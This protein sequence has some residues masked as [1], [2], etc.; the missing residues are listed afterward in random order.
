[1]ANP[2]IER[3][4]LT[5][6]LNTPGV[7]V[8]VVKVVIQGQV[9][10]EAVGPGA[11]DRVK[12]LLQPSSP[13]NIIDFA[14]A[15]WWVNSTSLFSAVENG[16][17]TVV[18]DASALDGPVIP[19]ARSYIPEPLNPQTGDMLVYD[20]VGWGVIP[21]GPAG[22]VITSGGPGAIPAYQPASSGSVNS[23]TALTPLNSTGGANPVISVTGVIGA[24]N[25][26]TGLSSPGVLGNVLTSTGTGW[27]SSAPPSVSPGAPLNS[28]QY[29]SA[30][31]FAGDAALTW[32]GS[33]LAVDG[34]VDRA[35]AGTLTIGG[36]TATGVTIG[37]ASPFTTT[38]L[39]DVGI[40]GNIVAIRGQPTSFPETNAT[41]VLT[42]NGSGTLSWAASGTQSVTS[43][44][45]L[46]LDASTDSAGF[47]AIGAFALTAGDYDQIDF[48]SL[49]VVT[50]A[51]LT[52]IVQL[53]NLT[54][55]VQVVAHSRVGVTSPSDITSASLV[56]PAGKRIYEVRHRVTGGMAPAD[57]VFTLWAGFVLT[58][59]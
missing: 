46:V 5:R 14:E 50:G 59:N 28:V 39:G 38:F 12:V 52:G 4:T 1:M 49:G 19:L 7:G 30:G 15:S 33:N 35:T 8:V 48:V 45:P 42:N 16:F 10:V 29:N 32:D 47:V 18:T 58:R 22:Y 9:Q 43:H 37:Q 40:Q 54:D 41:G 24:A 51:L 26:G 17:I 21:A 57:R 34:A 3:A 36:S 2:T 6:L 23:V 53:W 55:S 31:S 20:G 27:A 13:Q 44:L 11:L 56:L 25:G